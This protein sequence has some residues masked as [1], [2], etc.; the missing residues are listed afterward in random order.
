MQEKEAIETAYSAA[1]QAQYKVMLQAFIMANGDA[2]LEKNAQ[3]GFK[4]G[5]DIARRAR[6]AAI[7]LY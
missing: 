6:E 5:A 4:A 1:L 7:A 2:A 3:N